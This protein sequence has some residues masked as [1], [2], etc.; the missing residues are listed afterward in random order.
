ML[1]GIVTVFRGVLT[2]YLEVGTGAREWTVQESRISLGYG[3]Q[4]HDRQCSLWSSS[5][6]TIVYVDE[7]A[8]SEPLH[9]VRVLIIQTRMLGP[10]N[11][12]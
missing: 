7:R 5:Q 8:C 2:I 1:R 12:S 6:A 11:C 3:N 4:Q 9:Y 10:C